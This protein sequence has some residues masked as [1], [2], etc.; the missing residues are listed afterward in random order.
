M[1]RPWLTVV[2]IVASLESLLSLSAT[3]RI[4]PCNTFNPGIGRTT[5]CVHWMPRGQNVAP[6]RIRCDG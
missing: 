1:S 4:D 3:N 6:S 2:G 5:K